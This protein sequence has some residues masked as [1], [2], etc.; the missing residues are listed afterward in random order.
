MNKAGHGIARKVRPHAFDSKTSL[1][2]QEWIAPRYAPLAYQRVPLRLTERAIDEIP[3]LSKL[4]ATLVSHSLR[5]A[6]SD[7]VHSVRCPS[8]EVR[9]ARQR[10]PKH[11]VV[12]LV[13]LHSLC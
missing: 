8:D 4:E 13:S 6:V 3:E 2:T 7:L 1:S 5:E 10:L 9:D 11:V 12:V